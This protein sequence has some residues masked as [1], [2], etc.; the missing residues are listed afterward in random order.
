MRRHPCVWN[1]DDGRDD[2]DGNPPIYLLA[3]FLSIVP[4]VQPA[5]PDVR[6]SMDDTILDSSLLAHPAFDLDLHQ[7][8]NR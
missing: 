1:D 4:D 6:A 2:H 3:D 5:V 7:R 8:R